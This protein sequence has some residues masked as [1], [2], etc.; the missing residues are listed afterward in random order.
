VNGQPR[1]RNRGFL[2]KVF[3]FLTAP[4]SSINTIISLIGIPL[5]EGIT[6]SNEKAQVRAIAISDLQ[7]KVAQIEQERA[8]VADTLRE[9][10]VLQVIDFDTI[11]REFQVSQEIVKRERLRTRLLEVD[12][13][14]GGGDTVAF[15][16]NLSGLDRQKAET[17]KAWAKVRSQLARIKLLVLGTQGE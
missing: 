15:L 1:T 3:G 10:V 8:K 5:L 12:Y 2:Q 16:G 9:Q 7:V 6:Q 13:R 11:R 14:F 4:V 17:L